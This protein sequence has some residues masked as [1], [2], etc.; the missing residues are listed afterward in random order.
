MAGL[1]LRKM[2]TRHKKE[3]WDRAQTTRG[4]VIRMR[5]ILIKDA[6]EAMTGDG[7][8][9]WALPGWPGFAI[10]ARAA[11]PIAG[12]QQTEQYAGAAGLLRSPTASPVPSSVRNFFVWSLLMATN[13]FTL[14]SLSFKEVAK[15]TWAEIGEDD[16]FG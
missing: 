1:M 3:T 11:R 8:G 2:A 7:L 5:P 4:I 14:S 13:L 15:R 12:L 16:V 9:C 10:A 6:A